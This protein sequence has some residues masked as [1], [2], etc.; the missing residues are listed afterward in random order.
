MLTSHR[1]KHF[2]KLG[3][4]LVL[5]AQPSAQIFAL[6]K[7]PDLGSNATNVQ[8]TEDYVEPEE[9]PQKLKDWYAQN[10][11]ARSY[12]AVDAETHR[13]LAQKEGNTP[14]PIASMSKVISIYLVY[15][16]L[17]EGTLKMDQ[18]ITVSDAIAE[19]IASNVNLSNV[20]LVAGVEYSVEDLIY[21]VML[22]SGND[23]T[24]ALMW[25][26]YGSEEAAVQAIRD[27]LQA[28]NITNFQFYSTSGA[29]N[30]ELPESLWVA[31][32][33]V[34]DENIMSASDVALMTQY[35]VE[36]Y[37]AILD[38]TSTPEYLFKEG[39]E[40]ERPLYNPN[41]LLPGALYGRE[42]NL[43]VKSGFT[44]DAGRNFVAV[45]DENGR[46]IV[47]VVM[48]VVGEDPS[49][50]EPLTAYWD[51]EILLDGLLDYP[52]LYQ[53]EN[54]PTNLPAEPEPEEV[55]EEAGEATEEPA[56]PNLENRRDNPL[57]NFMRNIFS[58]FN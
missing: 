58:I 2:V 16:A 5:F 6:S 34:D 46:R 22:E 27:Q 28:W 19:G 37:P 14:Y 25:E 44:D 56:D 42:G 21:G 23:A 15:K 36:A 43:G 26:I 9:Y 33:G 18:M 57:T 31:G 52:E 20:G 4:A 30:E 53:N 51:Q 17:D 50:G 39:T 47:S 12:I 35:A 48:G 10:M 13:V 41:L 38:V 45:G 49:T 7:T 3:L 24:S 29:P 40:Y 32:S 1:V 8:P 11:D 54:L 55:E